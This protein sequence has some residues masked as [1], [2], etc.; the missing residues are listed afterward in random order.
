M[1]TE[2]GVRTTSGNEIPADIVVSATGFN[3][4]K[5]Y[6]VGSIKLSVDGKAYDASKTFMHKGCMM[7]ETP[8]LCFAIGYTNASCT[9]R[10]DLISLYLCQMLKHMV[11]TVSSTVTLH[12]R[13]LQ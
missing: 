1:F 5:N 13:M 10:T 8:N 3:F 11:N 9:L 6:P 2:T 4:M 7:S 12:F